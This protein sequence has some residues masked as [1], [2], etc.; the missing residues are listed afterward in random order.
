MNRPKT[1]LATLYRF[2][3]GVRDSHEEMFDAYTQYVSER[4]LDE[5]H[6]DTEF[7]EVDGVPAIWIGIQEEEKEAEWTEEFTTTTGLDL[8]YS[9]R[10]CGGVLLLGIDGTAYA[11]SYGNGY[12]LIPDELTD[13][14][15]GLS[16]LIRRLDAG[17][18]RDLVRRRANARGRIDSTV[19][20]AGAP[21]WMLGVAENVEIIRR[22]GGRAKDLKVTFSSADD[23]AVNVEGSVGL[24]MR[25]GVKPDALVADIREC[26]RVCREEEPDPALEFIEYVQP[27]TDTDTKVVLDDEL[28]KL[29]AATGADAGERLIP[30]VPTSVL[31]HLGQAHTYT[32]KIGHGRADL[33]PSL[34][35]EDIIRRTRVQRD[36]ER[37]K[38]LRCG[39]VSLNDDE[40]GK[41]VLASASADKWLEANVSYGAR[42]FFLMDGDW[43]ETG[44]DY[45]R[46]SRDAISRLFSATPTISLPPWSLTRRRTEYDY[47]C[48]VA[49]WSRGKYL[50][51]D[52]NR[53]VR[54]PLG[55]R[56]PLEICDLLGPGNELIHVK[57][58]EGSAPLSHLFS[59]GLI[60]A[61]SLVA[62]P[63]A[64][65]ERFVRTVAALPHGRSLAADF[66]PTKV[67][68]AILLPKGKQLTPDTLFPFSQ[69]TLAHAARILGTYGIDVEVVGI[70]AA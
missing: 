46:A 68:Y 7:F 13:Q 8:A 9:E 27:V 59:Q 36:G 32:I 43:F 61:Q 28:E 60:S 53:A 64:V 21:V 45:V 48:Y 14:R 23:R 4:S 3:P 2:V 5:R 37:V 1:R 33:S 49:A 16:F 47:N 62:G 51:L 57:R 29:L 20:A 39:H 50:C 69:A 15:F 42:R 18:V 70:P 38:T 26:A 58:A 65:L 67:V 11:L 40:A 10:R 44:A 34:E 55:A 30:V 22:I 12:R 66:K 6:A 17:Q 52:K 54:D 63:S 35:L 24:R 31:Q 25:F 56:S 41:E 19:V